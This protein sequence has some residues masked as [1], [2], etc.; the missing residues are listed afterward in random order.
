MSRQV[1]GAA[2]LVLAAGCGGSDWMLAESGYSLD[3][4]AYGEAFAIRV[5]V[6]ELR[7]LGGDIDS[8]LF[9]HYVGER[10]K[11]NRLCPAGWERQ[12]CAEI[13]QCVHRTDYSV[14]VYGRCVP[15]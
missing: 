13:E 3:V 5:H 10:L 2:A 6:N 12:L 11:R 14:T 8:P 1:L 4:A 15:Q 7:Q 9:H